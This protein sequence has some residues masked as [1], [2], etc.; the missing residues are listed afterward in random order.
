MSTKLCK[1]PYSPRE[2]PAEEKVL[3]LLSAPPQLYLDYRSLFL[4]GECS[5]L[6]LR[7]AEHDGD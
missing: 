5:P 3:A 4:F 7:W 6:Y 1:K 2:G